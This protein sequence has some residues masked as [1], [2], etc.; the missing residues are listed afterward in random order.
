MIE[1]RVWEKGE[2]NPKS[3][4]CVDP[5]DCRNTVRHYDHDKF[6]ECHAFDA[7]TGRE[8]QLL[9]FELTDMHDDD[10]IDFYSY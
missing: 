3:I 1:L 2:V 10:D 5:D 6:S 8:L 4:M 7:M 9:S